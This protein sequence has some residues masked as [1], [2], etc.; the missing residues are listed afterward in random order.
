MRIIEDMKKYIMF[1][2]ER[3]NN[4]KMLIL[5]E[6]KTI[7]PSNIIENLISKPIHRR[8]SKETF[9]KRDWGSGAR[10]MGFDLPGT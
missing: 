5:S 9:K 4:I 2:Q 3:L 8:L 7:K 6:L 1:I 10:D